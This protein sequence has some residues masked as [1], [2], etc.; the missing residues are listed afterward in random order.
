MSGEAV[1]REEFHEVLTSLKR[2]ETALLGDSEM[3]ID[4][5]AKKVDSHE[6]YIERDK[7]MK[8]K[9]AGAGIVAVPLLSELWQ[10]MK[11]HIFK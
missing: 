5:M 10:W 9:V 1:T 3:R 6:K 7:N 8:A 11:E 2:I 4:G